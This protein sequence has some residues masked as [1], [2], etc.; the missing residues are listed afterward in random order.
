MRRTV[1]LL[2]L[3]AAATVSAYTCD[4]VTVT[5]KDASY[6]SYVSPS[7]DFTSKAV[8][9]PFTGVT[10]LPIGAFVTVTYPGGNNTL[11]KTNTFAGTYGYAIT[12][13]ASL[14]ECF[15]IYSVKAS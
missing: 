11:L 10:I 8:T 5:S 2:C 12:C 15:G 4:T 9:T 6:V 1:A 14:D 3:L 13:T 7:T